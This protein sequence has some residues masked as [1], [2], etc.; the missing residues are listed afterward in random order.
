M[1]S[2][3]NMECLIKFSV[4]LCALEVTQTSGISAST[5][6]SSEIHY[7]LLCSPTCDWIL[8]VWYLK[9]STCTRRS[10]HS[11]VY[12]LFYYSVHQSMHLIILLAS[13]GCWH[14]VCLLFLAN[15]IMLSLAASTS[16]RSGCF[17]NLDSLGDW[18][19]KSDKEMSYRNIQTWLKLLKL[20]T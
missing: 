17:W 7:P 13:V 18:L 12:F 10:I 8:Q 1:V 15:S 4:T 2:H 5:A 19:L 14:S 11:F 6:L 3:R 9:L 16:E 20:S